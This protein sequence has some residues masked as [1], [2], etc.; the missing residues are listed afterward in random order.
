MSDAVY[1]QTTGRRT[2]SYLDS[3]LVSNPGIAGTMTRPRDVIGHKPYGN[4]GIAGNTHN[5]W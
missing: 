5:A 2:K 3:E 4:P 1:H